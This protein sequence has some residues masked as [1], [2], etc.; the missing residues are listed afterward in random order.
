MANEDTL[1]QLRD[2]QG[3]WPT[4]ATGQDT[5]ATAGTAEQLN[6][7]TSLSVPDAATATSVDVVLGTEQDW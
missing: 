1:Q 2:A 4:V 3:T 6:S 7:G 5:V